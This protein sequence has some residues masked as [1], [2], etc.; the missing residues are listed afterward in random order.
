ME[1]HKDCDDI[2]NAIDNL[3][4]NQKLDCAVKKRFS[5]TV[6]IGGLYQLNFEL[7]VNMKGRV[8]KDKVSPFAMT[9]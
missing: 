8:V 6:R 2:S 4:G 7:L 1:I 5:E 3:H 9:N